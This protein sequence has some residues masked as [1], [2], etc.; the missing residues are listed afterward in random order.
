MVALDQILTQ[1]EI[2]ALLDTMS[3]AQEAPLSGARRS[4]KQYDFRRPDKFSKDQVRAFQSLHDGFA[5]LLAAAWSA[6]LRA[7]VRARVTSVDQVTYGEFVRSLPDITVIAIFSAAPLKGV[8]ILQLSADIAFSIIDRLL[9]GTGTPLHNNRE[10]TEIERAIIEGVLDKALQNLAEAWQGL[11]ELKTNIEGLEMNLQFTPIT[12]ENEA[13]LLI[14]MEISIN[15]KVGTMSL[16][17]P[18][19]FLEGVMPKLST[20]AWMSGPTRQA[21]SYVETWQ[22]NLRDVRLPLIVSLRDI[23]LPLRELANLQP[24][25]V[26]VLNHGIQEPVSVSIGREIRFRGQI[27]TVRRHLAVQLTEVVKQE[28]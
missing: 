1:E 27:G 3:A 20:Q 13:T 23:Q 19:I 8:G 15:D 12:A 21:V 11:V 4:V 26:V 22:Q 2:N 5:R 24:G 17:F 6:H 18:A 7:T 14:T 28:E 25:D 16:C 10:L 9:G